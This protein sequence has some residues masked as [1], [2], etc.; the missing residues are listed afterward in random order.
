M[1]SIQ[2]ECF[3]SRALINRIRFSQVLI[4]YQ[5]NI[6]LFLDNSVNGFYDSCL[7]ILIICLYRHVNLS[8]LISEVVRV[9]KF[10]IGK[11]KWSS[12]VIVFRNKHYIVRVCSTD[13]AINIQYQLQVHYTCTHIYCT[14]ALISPN[15]VGG[16]A[17]LG[18]AWWSLATYRIQLNYLLN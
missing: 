7:G 17:L 14:C 1:W 13:Y 11:Q 16:M 10:E 2:P 4:R 15:T 12:F 6:I 9:G 5:L 3:L 18:Y 8:Y